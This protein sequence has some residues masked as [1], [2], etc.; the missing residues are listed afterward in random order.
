PRRHIAE[1]GMAVVREHGSYGGCIVLHRAG[2]RIELMPAADIPT[3]LGGIAEFNIANAL[4]AVAMCAAQRMPLEAIRDG[5]RAFTAS[6][7]DSPGRLNIHDAHGM[8]CILDYAH[9]PAG[10]RALGQVIERMRGR[11]NRVVGMVSIPGDRRNCDIIEMGG[12]AASL[13]DEI[14]FREAPDGRGRPRGETNG[15]MS[16]GA[17]QA[18][19]APD[20]LH[21]IVDEMEA[22][23]TVLNLGRRGDLLVIMPSA[24][25]AVWDRILAF[26][27]AEQEPVH[28]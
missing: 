9:N 16:Q 12:L 19:M 14:V 2:E 27:P 7:E 20:R 25:Q 10:L 13:F 8:R 23:D 6:F 15:L 26:E 21:R 18:G 11:Y 22:V 1:G 4:A 17:M 24:I 5:L 3:T 28:A